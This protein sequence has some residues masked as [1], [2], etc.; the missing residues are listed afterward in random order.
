MSNEKRKGL[1][2]VYDPHN[3]YQF[4]WYYATYG[5]D[6]EWDALC[7]PNGYK[8]E[9]M[10]EY[11]EKSGI[12]KTIYKGEQAYLSS[13]ILDR[14]VL[15][16]KMVFYAVLKKQKIM[17]KKIVGQYVNI[18]NYDIAVVLTDVGIVS[19]AVIGVA[20]EKEVV[21]LEDGMGDYADRPKDYLRKHILNPFDWQGY[22]VAKMGYSNPA[23]YYPLNTTNNLSIFL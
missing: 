2:V 4:I 6:I 14:G 9:Y 15:F 1:A 5:K 3:L 19:G 13:S 11:C 23:H 20:D 18:D 7:L 8:G 12:F 17:C 16:A 10:S 21:I 22:F